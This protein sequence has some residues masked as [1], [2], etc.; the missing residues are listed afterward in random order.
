M[1]AGASEIAPPNSTANMSS[2]SAAEQDLVAEHE[3]QAFADAG[4]HRAAL[5]LL[6]GLADRHAQQGAGSDK[7]EQRG[8]R[9]GD[10]FARRT[11]QHA[12][13]RRAEHQAGLEHHAADAGA[14]R[15]LVAA[16]HPREQRVVDRPEEGTRDPADGDRQVDRPQA[17]QRDTSLATSASS[18]RVQCQHRAGGRAQLASRQ[19][20]DQVAGERRHAEERDDLGQADQA[21]RP[22]VAGEFV[23][24]PAH[25]DRDDLVRE[26]R[27]DAVQHQPAEADAA[28][29][30][31]RR[32]RSSG[33]AGPGLLRM[34]VR[35]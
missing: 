22:R 9:V 13:D 4:E 19:V 18:E 15:E 26:Q 28:P 8:Q 17:V 31:T 27:A 23:D 34:H 29:A 33:Q 24:M 1:K 35:G 7:R 16:Q 20:V 11:D 6:R 10:P 21:Q 2:A 5:L 30:A 25:G 3:A 32:C 12:A 14:A